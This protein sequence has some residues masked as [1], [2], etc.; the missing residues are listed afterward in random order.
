MGQ[1]S[2]TQGGDATSSLRHPTRQ[3]CLAEHTHRYLKRTGASIGQFVEA[4][5]AAYERLVPVGHRISGIV[6]DYDPNDATGYVDWH[7]RLR[8]RV[9]RWLSGDTHAQIDV[10]DVWLEALPEPYRTR[11]IHDLS[12][13]WGVLP[14]ARP[15]GR[16]PPV[17]LGDATRETGE[18]VSASGAILADGRITRDDLPQL[19]DAIREA[20]EAAAQWHSF[21][22]YLRRCR[23]DLLSEEGRA[24][25]RSVDSGGGETD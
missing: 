16:P 22:Q 19:D 15:D 14:V 25:I 10:E 11:C 5:A 9:E 3:A 2:S 8:K 13:R 6:A 17:H 18:A 12:D 4:L 20:D 7:N 24:H 1:A 21:A 23:G